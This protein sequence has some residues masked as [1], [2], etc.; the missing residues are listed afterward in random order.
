MI[1]S[2]KSEKGTYP[3]HITPGG[4]S[5]VKE[6]FDLERK[7]LILTDENIPKEYVDTLAKNI[8]EPSL[9]VLKPGE[10]SK[11]LKSLQE[12]VSFMLEKGFD[13]KSA[14]VALGGG[15]V[16]DLGG[17]VAATF[18]RGIDFYNIPTTV[19]SQVDSSI[20]GKVAVNLKGY[21]NMIGAFYPPKGVLVDTET[22]KTLPE[23][24]IANGLSESVKMALTFDKDLF[25]L[26][27]KEDATENLNEIIARSLSLKKKVVEEDEKE[28]GLRRVL[29]FGHTLGHAIEKQS[30]LEGEVLYHGE[31]VALGMIPMCAPGVRERLLSVLKKLSLPTENPY[32]ADKVLAYMRHDKKMDG[33]NI[34]CVL[35]DEIGSFRM[36]EMAFSDF[37]LFLKERMI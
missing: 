24:Q 19:L 28:S 37:C 7:C 2:V 6:I 29:N 35:V 27:E 31:C 14:V 12:I 11:T 8:K 5:T 15:V 23:R 33:E 13:R 26:F 32:G 1:L 16:G 25:S 18:Q 30:F 10:D 4:L 17:F 9:F 20:G 34:H 3:V 36:E 22:L 21:K